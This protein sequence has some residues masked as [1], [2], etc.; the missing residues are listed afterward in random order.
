MKRFFFLTLGTLG[1]A[2]VT[3]CVGI[4]VGGGS[5]NVTH[6]SPPAPPPVVILTPADA[7]TRAEI[8]AAAKL[9]MDAARLSA[10]QQLA[11]RPG[12][13]PGNQVHLVN[14]AYRCLGF[15]SS[16]VAVLQSLIA[17]PSFSDQARQAIAS[18]TSCLSF[19]SSRQTILN[20]LNRRAVGQ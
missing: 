3:G 10:L 4:S 2:I 9:D 16:K 13:D 5:K 15:D 19:D 17:N 20:D 18:Q 8:D 14:T 12:L 6:P 1:A 11:Q 7:A